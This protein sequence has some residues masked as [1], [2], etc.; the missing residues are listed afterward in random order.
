MLW[1]ARSMER[2]GIR[3][4]MGCIRWGRKKNVAW[5]GAIFFQIA[6]RFAFFCFS[7]FFFFFLSPNENDNQF[8]LVS[9]FVGASR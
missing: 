9:S 2:G 7:F 4:S 5:R 3:E 6:N 1:S 8:V